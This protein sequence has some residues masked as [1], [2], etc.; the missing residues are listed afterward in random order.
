MPRGDRTGPAGMGPMTGRAAGYCAGYAVPGFAN[1][2]PGQGYG[3]GF[4]RGMGYGFRGGRGGRWGFPYAG[5]GYDYAVPFATPYGAAPTRQQELDA[6]Q[7]QANYFE[8]ALADIKKRIDDLEDGQ[9]E[10]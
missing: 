4:G 6:L 2:V 1:P 9:R 5:Y 10:A 3:F 8:E 7:G